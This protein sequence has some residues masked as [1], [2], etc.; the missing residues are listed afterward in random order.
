MT[1]EKKLPLEAV[2]FDLDGTLIDTVDDFVLSINE[3]CEKRGV[4]KPN[5][6][7]FAK[8]ISNGGSGMVSH[9]FNMPIDFD[10]PVFIEHLE[11]FLGIYKNNNGKLSK[12]FSS[13]D[14][15]IAKLEEKNITWGI[16]TNK[17]SKYAQPLVETLKL[18]PACLVCPDHVAVK[19]PDPE[20]L[21][22]AC[23]QANIKNAKNCVY[24]GD[25]RRDIDAG[26]GAEMHT[27][28][29]AYGYVEDSDPAGEW[30]A[31]YYASTPEK[32][33]EILTTHFE[34]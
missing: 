27:I 33:T 34:F 16:I 22:L 6:A 26:K 2:L 17:H 10:N 8:S 20:G 7:E 15:L 11:E 30:Q 12:L 9:G 5:P 23:K 13:L 14:T 4:E 1:I 19:K 32:I 25:H 18:K 24:I 29:A 31:D 3:Q 21:F 28:A